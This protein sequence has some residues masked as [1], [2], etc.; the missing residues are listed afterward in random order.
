MA[1]HLIMHVIKHVIRHVMCHMYGSTATAQPLFLTCCLYKEAIFS[2]F[3][4]SSPDLLTKY[5]VHTLHQNSYSHYPLYYYITG[6]SSILIVTQYWCFITHFILYQAIT[7]FTLLITTLG[8]SPGED[9]SLK[10]GHLPLGYSPSNST[11]LL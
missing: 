5:P 9:I 3:S 4:L 7:T 6:H 11:P 1:H 10:Q 8:S 2:P